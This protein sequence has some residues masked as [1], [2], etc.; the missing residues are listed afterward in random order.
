MLGIHARDKSLHSRHEYG[1]RSRHEYGT[2]RH[3]H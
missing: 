3:I 2:R 1:L